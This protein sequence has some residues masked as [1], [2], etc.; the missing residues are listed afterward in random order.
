VRRSRRAFTLIE[1]ITVI[2]ITAILL[3][4]IFLPV[5]QGFNLTRAAQA[6]AAAQDKARNVVRL[7]ERSVGNASGVRDNSGQKGSLY[8]VVPGRAADTWEPVLL[9]FVKIDLLKP[10]EGEPVRGP[11]GAFIN[12]DTGKEDPTLRAPKGQPNLPSVQGQ[13]I[14]RWFVGLRQPFRDVDGD[15]DADQPGLYFNPYDGLLQAR[16][17][18]R[19]NLYVLYRA[20]VTPKVWNA[21]AGRYQVDQRYFQDADGDNVPDDLDDPAFFTLMPGVDAAYPSG[22]LTAAGQAKALRIGNWLRAATVVTEVSRYDMVAAVFNKGSRLAFYDGNVPRLVP[23]VRFQPTRVTSEP[24]AGQA[25]L[26]SGYEVD[27]GAKVGP[28]TFETQYG[29]WT[30]ILMRLWPSAYPAA[31]GPASLSAGTARPRWGVGAAVQQPYVVG[32]PWTDAA[33]TERF[34]LFGFDPQ[35]MTDDLAEGAELFDVTRYQQVLALGTSNLPRPYAFSAAVND[36]DG[37]SG[38]LAQAVWRT[39]FVPAAPGAKTGKVTASFESREVGT[40]PDVPYEYRVPTYGQQSVPGGAPVDL[41]TGVRVSPYDPGAALDYTPNN[42]PDIGTGAFSDVLFQPVNR[43]F[44]KLW[45]DFPTLAPSLDRAQYVK[46]YIDL[47][48]VPQADG[49]RGPLDP[50]NGIARAF[51]TPGSETV[52]GP[53]QRPGPN[54]GRYVRYARTTRKPVGPNQYYINYVDQPEPDWS[55]LQLSGNGAANL[56]DPLVYDPTNFVQAVLQPQ[57]R[58]GYVELNSKFGEPIPSGYTSGGA[59]FPTG[60]VFVT[61]RFQFTE[62]ADVLAVDYDSSQVIEINLTIKNHPQSSLPN[63]QTVTVRGSSEVRNFL[64]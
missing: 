44:N 24:A 42:D 37:R 25:A 6:F 39:N 5:V 2:A 13:T 45:A 62:P 34:S 21:G 56:Y 18:G 51:V 38:W 10:S 11:S 57:Y 47:R 26:R 32:R 4:I 3:T 63:A 1:L 16:S 53:D 30:S 58:A 60:N 12:P 29:S 54:Y 43:R 17:G 31:W 23:M 8:V 33:G 14:E 19:D 64:R 36:A 9:P 59:F 50:G 15:G 40:D 22:G 20:E 28:D 7:L 49:S 46:R 61:Y 55:S 48:A 41:R 27:N 52:I 35:T